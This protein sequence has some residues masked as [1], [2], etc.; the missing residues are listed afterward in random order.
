VGDKVVV[1]KEDSLSS[2]VLNKTAAFIWELCD[3]SLDT[4]EIAARVHQHFDIPFENARS[5]AL[6]LI[7]ELKRAGIMNTVKG[8]RNRKG[9]G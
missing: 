7:E 3:G 5:D 6:E 1:I 2:H 8:G 9:K 4:D